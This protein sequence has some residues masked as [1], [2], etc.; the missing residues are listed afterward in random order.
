[1]QSEVSETNDNATYF[2][3][4]LM[5]DGFSSVH[6]VHVNKYFVAS[7]AFRPGQGTLQRPFLLANSL[8]IALKVPFEKNDDSN[9]VEHRAQSPDCTKSR[10]KID[11]ES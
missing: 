1:M 2:I 7:L 4:L 11:N 10:V 9:L 5:L 8:S 3:P 6:S